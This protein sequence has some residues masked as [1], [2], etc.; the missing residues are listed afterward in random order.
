MAILKP[1]GGRSLVKQGSSCASAN[2]LPSKL[3]RR[4]LWKQKALQCGFL[5]YSWGEKIRYSFSSRVLLSGAKTSLIYVVALAADA[6]G[7]HSGCYSNLAPFSNF[8]EK[9]MSKKSLGKTGQS[10]YDI[11][12]G[13][14]IKFCKSLGLSIRS[15]IF[16]FSDT[17][18][19]KLGHFIKFYL[20]P[21]EKIL[22]LI[23]E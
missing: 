20:T 17:P 12:G 19:D 10:N 1:K 11:K 5:S 6:C 8:L 21:L 22:V 14:G 9:R 2:F 4:V 3:C 16:Q 15:R 7:A 18:L 23:S 13:I